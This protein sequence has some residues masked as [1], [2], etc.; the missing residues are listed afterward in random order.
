M[1]KLNFLMCV[2]VYC[3]AIF[4]A[5]A[6]KLPNVQKEP[7]RAPTNVKIDGKATEWGRLQAYNYVTQISYT[8][9]NDNENLYLIVKADNP[10]MIQKTMMTGVNLTINRTTNKKDKDGVSI[11][12]PL[13]NRE[14]YQ[15]ILR[16]ALARFSMSNYLEKHPIT[17][18]ALKARKL[19]SVMRR[20][21]D[22]IAANAKFM[23]VTG[24]KDVED[25]ISVYNNLG[26]KAKARFDSKM[27][28]TYEIAIPLKYLGLSGKFAYHIVLNG[29]DDKYVFTGYP[30]L[31]MNQDIVGTTG[32]WG[33]YTLAK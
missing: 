10:Q 24:L 17:D 16:I 27:A 9:A 33:E 31:P 3:A 32:F 14:P 2:I 15:R 19:D 7:V 21:N 18:T 6:Q 29:A 28:L 11:T 12:F 30:N 4:S 22:Q 5:S 26:I 1:T 20:S 8:L 13:M 23:A 25:T